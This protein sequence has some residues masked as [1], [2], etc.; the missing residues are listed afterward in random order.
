[1]GL[2]GPKSDSQTRAARGTRDRSKPFRNDA[3]K[4]AWGVR[5]DKL[6]TLGMAM[7]ER[8]SGRPTSKTPSNGTQIAAQLTAGMKLLEAADRIWIRLGRLE[9]DAKPPPTAGSTPGL[10]DYGKKRPRPG[11]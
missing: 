11:A 5:A 8:A 9:P 10:A 6:E 7:I 3:A 4:R 2:R 1:M